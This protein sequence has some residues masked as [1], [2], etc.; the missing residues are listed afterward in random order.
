M[1]IRI[2]KFPILVATCDSLDDGSLRRDELLEALKAS[3]E[4]SGMM[5]DNSQ[6]SNMVDA[7]WEDAKV[8]DR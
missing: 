7:I 8:R 4:E 3:I 2:V 1:Q 5:F 6:L